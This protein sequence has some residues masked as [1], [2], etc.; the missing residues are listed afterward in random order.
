M[1]RMRMR[2]EEERL[3]QARAK[4]S[5]FFAAIQG[6]EGRRREAGEEETQG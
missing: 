3:V 4:P 2:R 6:G 1:G 5:V